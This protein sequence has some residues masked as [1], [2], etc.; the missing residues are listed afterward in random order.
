MDLSVY[1]T[2]GQRDEREHLA[3]KYARHVSRFEEAGAI[4]CLVVPY[5]QAT[6]EM[7]DHLA[8]RAALLSGFGRPLE[9]YDLRDFHGIVEWV[10]RTATPLLALCGS[11][12]LL[13]AHF[14]RDIREVEGLC[15]QPM[16]R[17][18][19]G[20]PVTNPDYH[21]GFY[22]ERGFYAVELTKE[23]R[24]DPLFE[25]LGPQPYFYESHY[26]EVKALPPGFRLLAS[27]EECRIQA[28]RHET[29]LLYSVQFHPE[30]YS[31]D[32]PGGRRLLESFFRL[33][34]TR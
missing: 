16:R 2:F 19:P 5:W 18:R 8:P 12:Q 13:S 9:Q 30:E 22:L 1:V 24:E 4:P 25:G 21:P 28:L 14:T 17:L 27:T 29:R 31:E 10:E 34:G 20:E 26:C 7:L 11:H 32:F 23:G 33:A 6:P 15:D 3:A